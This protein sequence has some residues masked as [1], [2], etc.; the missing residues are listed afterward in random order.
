MQQ[1][2]MIL[3]SVDDHVV[4]PADMWTAACRRE[5]PGA[6]PQAGSAGRRN[7]CVG[8]PR[9]QVRQRWPERGR[10]GPPED[11]GF[12]AQ[13]FDE[14]RSAVTTSHERVRDMSANG[15][16]AQLNFPSW[17]GFAARKLLEDQ[18]KDLALALLRGY[19]DWHLE[20][21]PPARPPTGSSPSA[22]SRCGIP[23]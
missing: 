6:G 12:D 10:R 18:D 17:P 23:S 9:H 5:V 8:V 7:R 3:I 21:W 16:L 1:E 4:E 19:N 15:V 20:S 14:M 22:S 13:S 11:W 2:D